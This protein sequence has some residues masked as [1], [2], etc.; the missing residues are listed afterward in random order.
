[1]CRDERA[2]KYDVFRGNGSAPIS[3][4]GWHLAISL[5]EAKPERKSFFELTRL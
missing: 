2:N 3:P 4:L 1:M 5:P